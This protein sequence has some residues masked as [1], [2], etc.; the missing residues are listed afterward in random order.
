MSGLVPVDEIADRL[1][2]CALELCRELLPNGRKAGNV[3]QFSGMADTGRSW[4]A[5]CYITGPRVGHWQDRGNAMAGEERGDML[6][7]IRI[8]MGLADSKAAIAEAK[9]RLGIHDTFEG[10]PRQITAE[11][12]AAQAEAARRR[13]QQREEEARVE[14]ERKARGARALYLSEDAVPIAGTPAEHYLRG[15]E[16]D[17]GAQGRWPNALR[18]HPAVWYRPE[19]VKIPAMLAPIYRA[20]GVHIGTHRT[21]LN[22]ARGR[23]GKIDAPDAK[24]VTGN[25]WGGFIP[26]A[27]GA[28]GKSMAKMPEGEPVYMCEGIEDALCIRMMRPEARVVTTISVGNMG[29]VILPSAARSLVMVCDRDDK[30]AAQ[31]Q[32]ER[33][34]AAQQARGLDVRTVMPPPPHKDINDWWRAIKAERER[35][36]A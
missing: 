26:I 17:A 4:S 14:F 20:D 15:R 1:N 11:E 12:R 7:L 9:A 6:D 25:M 22:L 24:K 10:R 2:A 16:I 33:A 36:A 13:A 23:W 3:W 30:V 27:K 21:Y 34:I 8:R 29:A 35:G 31:D 32:L 18:F 28:S 5:F 19:R